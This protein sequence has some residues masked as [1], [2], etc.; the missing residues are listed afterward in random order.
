MDSQKRK[1]QEKLDFAEIKFYVSKYGN[2]YVISI[3]P[4][5]E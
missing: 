4:N 5:N 3:T 1:K 2:S